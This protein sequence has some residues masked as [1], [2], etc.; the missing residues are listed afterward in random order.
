VRLNP[1]S[2]QNLFNWVVQFQLVC[3]SKNLIGL[4]GSLFF[5]GL[6]VG[7]L[8]VPRLSD[9]YGRFRLLLLGNMLHISTSLLI[10]TTSNIHVALVL[11]FLLGLAMSGRTIVMYIWMSEQ[12]T[13]R[14]NSVWTP[15]MF[16]LDTSIVL[17]SALYFRF[18]S[19]DYRYF[20]GVPIVFHALTL[21]FVTQEDESVKFYYEKH[22]FAQTRRILTKMGRRNGELKD[23]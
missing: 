20:Y 19:K 15:L 17:F 1:N 2:E 21:I 8:I 13:T 16:S 22:E 3:S 14:D 23:D 12:L 5:V 11:I 10:L 7:C 4:L 9:L 6:L 18:V